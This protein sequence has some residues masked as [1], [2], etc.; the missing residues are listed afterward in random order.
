VLSN[1]SKARQK[2]SRALVVEGKR[3]LPTLPMSR[4]TFSS[5]HAGLG[6]PVLTWTGMLVP[7]RILL[8]IRVLA[9]PPCDQQA[10]LIKPFVCRVHRTA[11]PATCLPIPL[12]APAGQAG[13]RGLRGLL[14]KKLRPLDSP[15]AD[16]LH[17]WSATLST[18]VE[19]EGGN[20]SGVMTTTVVGDYRLRSGPLEV[21]SGPAQVAKTL[22]FRM[23][24]MRH[25]RWQP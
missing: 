14:G 22:R 18:G 9:S 13:R 3:T 25:E 19:K 21:S 11:V 4:C 17:I 10:G 15:H 23:H 6:K 7:Y 8:L 1:R 5:T 24:A 16:H 20:A 2:R 12:V